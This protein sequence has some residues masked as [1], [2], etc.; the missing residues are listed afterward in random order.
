MKQG[1]RSACWGVC[2]QPALVLGGLMSPL[3]W[4]APSP[5]DIDGVLG[6]ASHEPG[7]MVERS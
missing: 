2:P 6:K 5:S 7:V 4:G 3:A 1:V